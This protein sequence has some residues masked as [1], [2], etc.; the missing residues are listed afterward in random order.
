MVASSENGTHRRA[1]K[2]RAAHVA[3]GAVA[4][5][6]FAP[7]KPAIR[8]AR[9]SDAAPAAFLLRRNRKAADEVDHLAFRTGQIFPLFMP[10]EHDAR[11]VHQVAAVLVFDGAFD[12]G[13]GA[14]LAFVILKDRVTEIVVTDHEG[15]GVPRAVL[16]DGR[17]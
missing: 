11:A 10:I 1:S 4:S 5:I 8:L 14:N 16:I 12:I 2:I 17:E 7:A 15:A 9:I 3:R 13:G 6:G